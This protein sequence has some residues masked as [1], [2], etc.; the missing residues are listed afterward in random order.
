M[1]HS[2]LP[3]SVPHS[4]THFHSSSPHEV[5]TRGARYDLVSADYVA[6]FRNKHFI[7]YHNKE[8]IISTK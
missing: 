8:I 2:A 4:M 1:G 7:S 6:V 3:D 5:C